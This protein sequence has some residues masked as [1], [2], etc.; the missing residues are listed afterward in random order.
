M[1]ILAS[2]SPRRKELLAKISKEPFKVI[3][4]HIDE[5]LLKTTPN[6][7]AKE[8]SKLKA[9]DVFENHPNDKVLSC[10]TIVIFQNEIYGKPHSKIEAKKMLKALSNNHHIVISAYTFISSQVEITRSVKTDVYFNELSDELIDKYIASG[11][12]MDKAGAY[13]IQDQEFNLVKKIDGSL[14]NVIGLPTED[15]IK[16]LENYI[17]LK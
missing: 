2:N 4:S 7:L 16:H 3:P 6:N 5:S 14:N 15:I 17:V 8:L 11:S 10:D 9:Y 1:L 13:G 12:P